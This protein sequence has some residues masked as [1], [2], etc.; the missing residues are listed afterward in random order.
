MHDVYDDDDD[1]DCSFIRLL[2]LDLLVGLILLEQ[3]CP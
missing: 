1:D 3:G 2:R